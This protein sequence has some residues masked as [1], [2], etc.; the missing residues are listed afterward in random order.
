MLF[1]LDILRYV[2]FI[3]ISCDL[4]KK[5]KRPIWDSDPRFKTIDLHN[6]PSS[7]SQESCITRKVN[8]ETAICG[9]RIYLHKY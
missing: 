9:S 4:R 5:A 3:K 7:D 1:Y 6:L 8:F 2:L